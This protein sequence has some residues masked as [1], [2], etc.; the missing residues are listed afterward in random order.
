MLLYLGRFLCDRRVLK[1]YICKE[2]KMWHEIDLFRLQ[3]LRETHNALQL[4][5]FF[6][7]FF[8][9]CL[10]AVY[11]TSEFSVGI[12]DFEIPSILQIEAAGSV[13]S[14]IFM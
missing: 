10:A 9:F 6:F 12:F 1:I 14:E 4:S 2:E 3:R 11:G 13:Y 7:C 5:V 8:L